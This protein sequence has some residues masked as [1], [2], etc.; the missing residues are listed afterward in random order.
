VTLSAGT[1][2]L[3]ARGNAAMAEGGTATAVTCYR[4]AL[5][6]APGH[7]GLLYNLGNALR[8][9]GDAAGAEAALRAS[10]AA[11]AG[12]PA[13]WNNLGTLLRA[14]GKPAEALEACRR[15]VHLAPA[16]GQLR[17]NLGTV[18]LDLHRPQEA[19][20]WLAQAVAAD[21]TDAQARV[22]LAGALMLLAEP[23]AALAHYRAARALAPTLAA[24]ALGEGLALLTLGTWPAGWEAY[25]AR[26]ADP[27]FNPGT[28]D[29]PIPR[30]HGPE[31]LA[32]KRLLLLSEQGMGDTLQCVRYL[33]LLRRLGSRTVLQVPPP[34]RRLLRGLA[35]RVVVP[36][37]PLGPI[38]FWCPLMSLPRAFATTPQTVP[39]APYLVAPPSRLRHWRRV[40]PPTGRLRVG[41]AWRGNPEHP[42][43]ALRSLPE[44]LLRPLL[45]IPGIEAHALPCE[46][47]ATDPRI[48][49][50][51]GITDFADTAALC[52]LMDVIVTVDT[53]VAHLA[54]ALGKRTAILL[55]HAPDFRWMLD[56]SDTPWYPSARL[57]RQPRPGDWEAVIAEVVVL[58]RA[59]LAS[60]VRSGHR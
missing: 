37:T 48:R 12:Q 54:G 13:A 23:R 31:P 16:D 36:G 52:T 35:E 11:D 42:F 56:R 8:A 49:C 38:D 25:E 50:Y 21:P 46:S 47:A 51:R 34:L 17:G 18:L 9:A 28:R 44:A 41:L 45:D 5:A 4:R 20:V 57:F 59:L 1:A 33:P 55:A 29:L 30:W 40:L 22:N 32:G 26:L 27:R 39:A 2:A 58:L 15:A 3:L 14:A 60:R 43:D 24:A 7:P 53:A 6:E 10:L 19:V